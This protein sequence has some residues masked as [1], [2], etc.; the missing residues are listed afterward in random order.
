[1]KA[2]SVVMAWNKLQQSNLC[3][4]YN[5]SWLALI[6]KWVLRNLIELPSFLRIF[7]ICRAW[8]RC[9]ARVCCDRK[10]LFTWISAI[11]SVRNVLFSSISAFKRRRKP[12]A[13][14]SDASCSSS[15]TS[16]FASL[17]LSSMSLNSILND[18]QIDFEN[19]LTPAKIRS[20]WDFTYYRD[21]AWDLTF[22][23]Y[24]SKGLRAEPHHNSVKVGK[25][26]L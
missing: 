23:L 12:C 2:H 22:F 14:C 5:G 10:S 24:H 11:W 13:S 9:I 8:S 7:W 1:M 17:T 26:L 16:L 25:R 3:S 15:I 20:C 19:R 6:G 21:V 4:F 18:F